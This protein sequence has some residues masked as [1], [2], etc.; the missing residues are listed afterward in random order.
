MVFVL[1]Q[2]TINGC[3]FVIDGWKDKHDVT[4]LM[5]MRSDWRALA[6]VTLAHHNAK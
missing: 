5:H 3:S 2:A 1:H 6:N 4:I